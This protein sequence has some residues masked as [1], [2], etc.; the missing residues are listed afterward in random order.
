M[1]FK[2]YARHSVLSAVPLTSLPS[3]PQPSGATAVLSVACGSDTP[4]VEPAIDHWLHAWN[5]NDGNVVLQLAVLEPETDDFSASFLLRAPAAGDFI[6]NPAAGSVS[7]R[8]DVDCAPNT[9]EHLLIDQVLPR[10]LA[11][12]GHMMVHASL[13]QVGSKASLFLGNSG[14]GKSTIAGLL[15]NQGMIALCDDCVLLEVRQGEVWA[16][17]AY[18]G[19]RLHEDSISHVFGDALEL[20][21]VA[22]YSRKQRVIGLPLPL[23]PQ[24]PLSLASIYL[25][26]DPRTSKGELSIKPL[27]SAAACIALVEHSF[28]LDPTDRDQTVRVL[29]QAGNVARSVPAFALRQPHDFKRHN[30]LTALLQEHFVQTEASSA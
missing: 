27:T 20:T 11:Q 8:A 5:D 1:S 3:H 19:L 28:R 7:V 6:L 24:A 14:W 23:E 17:P 16:T 13:V 25:L 29:H 2:E 21:R 26:G 18:P 10:M 15:H 4:S 12:R 22:H 30:Q 9:L